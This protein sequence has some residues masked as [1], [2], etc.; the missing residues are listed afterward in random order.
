MLLFCRL[1][2]N[3]SS[4]W[5]SEYL[6]RSFS[7][8]SKRS[9]FKQHKKSCKTTA[10]EPQNN[11]QNM[12]KSFFYYRLFVRN[13]FVIWEQ[14]FPFRVFQWSFD[15]NAAIITGLR[16]QLEAELWKAGFNEI[17]SFQLQYCVAIKSCLLKH[18]GYGTELFTFHRFTCVRSQFRWLFLNNFPAPSEVP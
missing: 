15:V 16:L 6:E 4:W 13:L 2:P 10:I 3:N 9:V 14:R 17:S 12:S 1:N 18:F 5:W 7:K 11:N 8:L